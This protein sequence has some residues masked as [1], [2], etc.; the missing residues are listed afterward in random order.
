MFITKTRRIKTEKNIET[1]QTQEVVKVVKI[2]PGIGNS[3]IYFKFN[4]G[5]SNAVRQNVVIKE[6]KNIL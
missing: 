5:Y 2:D 6:L 4:A 3:D 1:N